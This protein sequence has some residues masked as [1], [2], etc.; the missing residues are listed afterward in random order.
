[1]SAAADETGA[2]QEFG[3]RIRLD[4]GS[5]LR[6]LGLRTPVRRRL[7][8][9][10][11]SFTDAPAADA[12]AAWNIVWQS[13]EVAD[14]L[15]APLDFYR[16]RAVS[17]AAA[18]WATISTWVDRVDNWAHADDLARVYSRALAAEPDAVYPTLLGWSNTS[19]QWR[20]RISM[21]SLIRYTGKNATF[22][23]TPQVL[24]V[25]AN[26]VGD[27]R[28]HVT[29]AVGWVLRETMQADEPAVM[30]FLETHAADINAA[31]RRRALGGR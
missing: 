31:T 28:P 18:F 19:D 17:D 6:H 30:Q 7:V 13:S 9:H 5:E 1:M 20:R 8:K 24:D 27:E 10:G 22:M 12:L 2:T 25:V 21:V 4:R 23:P 26:C 29:K 16:D 11:F 15:F 3:E 14:V